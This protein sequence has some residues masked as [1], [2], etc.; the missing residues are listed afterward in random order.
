MKRTKRRQPKD[1]SADRP[2]LNPYAKAQ[3]EFDLMQ[4]A[5]VD[6]EAI[7]DSEEWGHFV[8]ACLPAKAKK[9]IYSHAAANI[10]AW[11]G[12][13]PDDINSRDYQEFQTARNIAQWAI[14]AGFSLALSLNRETLTKVLPRARK[15]FEEKQAQAVRLKKA[16]EIKRRKLE[17]IDGR[18]MDRDA[19]DA[20]I[21]REFDEL[22]ATMP[23]VGDRERHLAEKY[24]F[25]DRRH[26]FNIRKQARRTK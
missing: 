16:N 20:A 22:A 10:E 26:I 4:L 6:S 18:L 2:P 17:R 15:L 8:F 5:P 25:E 7:R 21:C 13:E 9:R 1:S 12:P 24:G 23:K 3:V 11:L 19:R 14:G